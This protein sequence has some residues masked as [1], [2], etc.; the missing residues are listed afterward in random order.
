[1]HTLLHLYVFS[2]IDV[3]ISKKVAHSAALSV[4]NSHR[5]ITAADP[6]CNFG[7]EHAD[8]AISE[9]KKTE[10][11]LRLASQRGKIHNVQ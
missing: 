1:M 7:V 2:F 9:E 5:T 6:M 3:K 8:C 11:M 4:I 10:A